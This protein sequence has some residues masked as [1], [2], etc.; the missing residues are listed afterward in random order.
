R[1][2]DEDSLLMAESIAALIGP[3]LELKRRNRRWFGG[4]LVDGTLH[5]LGV[6]LGPRRIGWKLLALVLAGLVIAAATVRGPFRVQAD[7][8]LRGAEQRAAV[9]PF[10]GFIAEAPLRAGDRVR[11]GDL[12]VRLDDS[13]LRLEELR[14]RS[15]VDRLISQSREALASH[16]RPQVALLEA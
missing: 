6:L 1:P 5:V 2:F 8:V 16:D 14:W 9:A 4:R 3:V 15:E 12:L 13:D 7:A 10:A 11:Q